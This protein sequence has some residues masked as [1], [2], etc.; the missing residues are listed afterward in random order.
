MKT[1]SLYD[2]FKTHKEDFETILLCNYAEQNKTLY[3]KASDTENKFKRKLKEKPETVSYWKDKSIEYRYNNYGFRTYD[4]FNKDDEGIVCLGCSFT[5]GIGLPLEYNWGYKLAKHFNLKHWNLGQ[6]AMGLE[7]AFRLL[8][9]V[10]DWLKFKKVFLFVPPF[11]RNELIVSDND[12]IEPYLTEASDVDKGFIH[13]MG[14][15]VDPHIFSSFEPKVTRFYESILYGSRLNERLRMIR[16]LCSI[17]GLCKHLGVE[18]YYQTFSNH[19]TKKAN[20]EAYSIPDN[21]CIDIP[22]RDQHWST[23]RQHL[24]FK[25]FI[26]LY[27]NNNR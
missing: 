17:Q 14:G 13:S 1:K 7:T 27:E 5:E 6:H 10:S 23:K 18:F 26:Q 8:L 15:Q 11:Y 24:I 22:A 19:F 20:Q 25:K 12:F 2:S 3:W 9:G 21:E 16:N 4:D